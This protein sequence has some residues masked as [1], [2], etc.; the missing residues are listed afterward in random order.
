MKILNAGNRIMNATHETMY[1]RKRRNS[2]T[3]ARR[4]VPNQRPKT[5]YASNFYRGAAIM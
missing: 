2:I 4:S 3:G 5:Q 1:C